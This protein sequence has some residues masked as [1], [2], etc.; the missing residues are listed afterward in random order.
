MEWNKAKVES[1]G[2]LVIAKCNATLP[3]LLTQEGKGVIS[4]TSNKST[5]SHT[6]LPDPGASEPIVGKRLA[7]TGNEEGGSRE[8]PGGWGQ[9]GKVK[10]QAVAFNLGCTLESPESF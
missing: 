5:N 3:S 10:S 2:V 4:E 7:A 9:G 8:T 1:G 6:G